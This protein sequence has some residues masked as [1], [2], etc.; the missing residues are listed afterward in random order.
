MAYLNV[1]CA[2]QGSGFF[3]GATPQLD[4]LLVDALKLVLIISI[5]KLSCFNHL[6]NS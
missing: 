3:A 5:V 1:D 2:V 6:E 4:G